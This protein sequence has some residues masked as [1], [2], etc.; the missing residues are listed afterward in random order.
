MSSVNKV[1]V[2]VDPF[3]LARFLE[4][5]ER[6]ANGCWNWTEAENSNGYGRFVIRGEQQLAHRAAYTLF[7]GDIP[8]G[9]NVCHR[10]DNRKCVN[11]E[12]LWLGTQS[13]NLTDA[14]VKGRMFRPDTRADKNGNTSLTWDQVRAIRD[15]HQSGVRKYRIAG[16]F[17]VSPSTI[18]N[19]TKH[20]T[21]KEPVSA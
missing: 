1:K 7:F 6:N 2:T 8:D 21:W 3:L 20:E 18:T 13:D 5:I 14:S 12:H 4:S 15:M 9:L 10:C 16:L 17:G 19:I 11:P